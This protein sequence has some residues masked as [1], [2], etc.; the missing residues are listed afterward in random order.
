[1][2]INNKTMAYLLEEVYDNELK[3]EICKFIKDSVDFKEDL[4]LAYKEITNILL[5]NNDDNFYRW[6]PLY[7]ASYLNK[8]MHINYNSIIQEKICIKYKDKY[9]LHEDIIKQF[10][11]GII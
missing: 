10:K 7:K 1:M 4:E 2:E 6:L 3:K 11:D 5:Y 9:I 8:K